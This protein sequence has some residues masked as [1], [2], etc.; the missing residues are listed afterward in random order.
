MDKEI[1][2]RRTI[3]AH[4]RIILLNLQHFLFTSHNILIITGSSIIVITRYLPCWWASFHVGGCGQMSIALVSINVGEGAWHTLLEY[5]L[6]L[7]YLNIKHFQQQKSRTEE[8]EQCLLFCC[9][10]RE[11][12][13]AFTWYCCHLVTFRTTMAVDWGV[14]FWSHVSGS[15]RTVPV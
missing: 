6:M 3:P 10:W 8:E 9:W 5:K 13:L 2:K 12:L 15:E 14:T 1:E 7:V 4:H 11:T